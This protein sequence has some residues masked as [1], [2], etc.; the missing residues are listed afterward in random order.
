MEPGMKY[1]GRTGISKTSPAN[2]DQLF[3]ASPDAK[4]IERKLWKA[5]TIELT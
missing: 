5:C 2:A 4:H 3:P 1:D